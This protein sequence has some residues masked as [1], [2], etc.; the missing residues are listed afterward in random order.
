MHFFLNKNGK[1]GK[2]VFDKKKKNSSF[3]CGAGY[4]ENSSLDFFP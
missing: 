4:I 2:I 1:R 3:T